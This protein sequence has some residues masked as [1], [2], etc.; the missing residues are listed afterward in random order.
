M[1]ELPEVEV[2]RRGLETHLVGRTFDTVDVLHPRAVRGNTEDLAQL[3]PGKRITGTGRRG[4][5]LWLTL[6]DGAALVVHLRMSGQM[7]V[8]PPGGVQSPH[9]R[10]R[11]QL[12]EIQ[13]DFVDQ[14]TFGMWQYAPFDGEVPA[15][16]AHIARDPFDPHFDRTA[17]ARV[18]RTRRSAL[19]TV[20]L[21][22]E[23]VSGIGSIYADEAMW[24]A[25]VKP[26]RTAR[27]LRQRDA[28]SVLV[29]AREVMERALAQG[30]TSFD[31]LYVNVNGASGYFSR[32]LNAYGQAG[33]PCAR[34]GTE[35][36]K[37]VVGG[38]SC[39]YCPACQTL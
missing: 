37:R 3:L 20:L 28:V 29:H 26:W 32:S 16:V 24:A 6:D 17:T 10:I 36:T 8:G 38:R 2:V 22:Q 1:P 5:Y 25:R 11:A 13:L 31:S 12:G 19:K 35:I 39:Y 27:A 21:N 23:L 34:C 14:R 9:V 33:R 15:P 30:G 4:K 7:L 18:M